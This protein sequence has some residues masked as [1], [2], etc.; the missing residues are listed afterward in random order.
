L[1]LGALFASDVADVELPSPCQD[2]LM[3]TSLLTPLSPTTGMD[4][5]PVRNARFRGDV[6]SAAPGVAQLPLPLVNVYFIGAPGAGDRE[7]CLVDAGL[8]TSAAAIRKAAASRFSRDSRPAAI[9][10]TH[11]HFDHVGSAEALAEV[12]DC[13]I[14]VHENEIPFVN[15]ESAYPPPDPAVGGGLMSWLSWT[16]PRGPYNLGERV[17][18]LPAGGTVPNLSDW[19]WIPTPGH[20]PGHVSFFR[21]SD[22]TLIAGDAFVTQPQESARGV[23]MMTPGVFRPPAYFTIDWEA[24][25][26]SVRRLK[27]LEPNIALTGHGVPMYGERLREGLKELHRQWKSAAQPAIGRYVDQPAVTG[28]HGVISVPPAVHNH[29][30]GLWLAVGIGAAVGLLTVSAV[31]GSRSRRK[32]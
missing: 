10:L 22:G 25:R 7:W 15:G 9:L 3:T 31:A 11:G 24:A 6:V 23:L 12:W 19:R 17:Q 13:P 20:T 30:Q 4:A 29:R 5:T 32:R 21:D 28:P 14:Y 16:Y 8:R 2:R 18:P 26:E 27:D 1:R